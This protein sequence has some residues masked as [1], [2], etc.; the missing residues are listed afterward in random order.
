M[1]RFDSVEEPEVFFKVILGCSPFWA[2]AR[3]SIF[4]DCGPDFG[5]RWLNWECREWGSMTWCF[6]ESS[7]EKDK[8]PETKN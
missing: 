1:S 4:L 8:V 6:L 7:R 2:P 3:S 5:A